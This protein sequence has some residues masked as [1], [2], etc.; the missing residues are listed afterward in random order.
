MSDFADMDQDERDRLAKRATLTLSMAQALY[1]ITTLILIA[2]GGLVGTM[3]APVKGL[4][5]LPIT[6]LRHWHGP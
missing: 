4:A 3:I 2:T 1:I 5:T 6:T